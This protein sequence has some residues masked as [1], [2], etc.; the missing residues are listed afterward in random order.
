MT[1]EQIFQNDDR[2]SVV[3]NESRS[4]YK[5]HLVLRL[6][7]VDLLGELLGRIM[8]SPRDTIHSPTLANL[9]PEN[10]PLLLLVNTTTA[11]C[12]SLLGRISTYTP[13]SSTIYIYIVEKKMGHTHEIFCL[14]FLYGT[15]QVVQKTMS[16]NTTRE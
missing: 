6:S 11:T 5:N 14:S 7:L 8:S 13:M 1:E 9:S 3:R 10:W 12:Y 4:G 16:N 2:Q 15:T